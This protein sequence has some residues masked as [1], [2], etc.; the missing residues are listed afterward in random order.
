M[1][2]SADYGSSGKGNPQDDGRTP[3]DDV[4]ARYYTTAMM[5]PE[6]TFAARR[7]GAGADANATDEGNSAQPEKAA[8][9]HHCPNCGFS[10]LPDDSTE[11]RYRRE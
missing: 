9:R 6:Q 11:D 7:Q 3:G 1:M 8:M 4:A 10:F 2:N 5:T